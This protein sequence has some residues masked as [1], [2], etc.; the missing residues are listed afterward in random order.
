VVVTP[1]G[2]AFS[3]DGARVLSG[4][5]SRIK[6][7]NAATGALI[8]TLTGHSSTI[9]SVVFSPNSR[10]VLS[11]GSDKTIKLWVIPERRQR[12][13]VASRLFRHT[14]LRRISKWLSRLRMVRIRRSFLR[15][16][17]HVGSA[18]TSFISRSIADRVLAITSSNS[19][20]VVRR[21]IGNST[22]L[23]R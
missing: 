14:A 1:R 15:R 8:R 23:C 12:S 20:T 3:P 17:L 16:E 19:R 10:Q 11:G 5:S 2:A 21:S 18:S 9:S 7:W 22:S 4:G 6:L 13:R